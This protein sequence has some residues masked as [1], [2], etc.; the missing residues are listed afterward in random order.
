FASDIEHGSDEKSHH[1]MEKAV[2]L[3][4]EHDS[5][6]SIEPPGA[7]DVAPMAVSGRRRSEH[8][9]RLK[10]VFALDAGGRC[11]QS[12]PIQGLPECQLVP[13]T[14]RRMCS[15]IRADVVAVSPAQSTVPR[16][17]LVLHL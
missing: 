6:R 9:K 11:I 8:R 2:G 4:L 12:A 17:K 1:V 16:M 14:E 13:T 15:I 5:T 7:R 10:A 3:D